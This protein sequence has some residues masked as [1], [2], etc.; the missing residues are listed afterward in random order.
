VDDRWHTHAE[1]IVA[2]EVFPTKR[3]AECRLQ[4]LG[5]PIKSEYRTGSV[6][7]GGS[8]RG[9]RRE[10]RTWLYLC[11]RNSRRAWWMPKRFVYIR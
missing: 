4:P 9:I 11:G 6:S 5:V 7:V 8:C 2:A 3:R 1:P 10:C